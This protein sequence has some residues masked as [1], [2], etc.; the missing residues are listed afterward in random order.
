METGLSISNGLGW[1]PDNKTFYLTDSPI[2]TIFAYDF[3]LATGDIANRRVFADLTQ[4]SFYPDGL[5]IDV[6]GCLWVAMWDGWCIVRF[7]P[8]GQE[9]T[10]VPM[11]VQR[12]TSCTF[13]GQNLKS[14]YITTARTGLEDTALQKAPEAGD[15][16]CLET[17][18]AGLPTY[19]LV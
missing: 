15:L 7:D 14:L 5:S 18:V 9:M 10:R 2:Q 17:K 11:P 3:D 1:S 13:G 6:E 12:P 19:R 16:F 4:E 8:E